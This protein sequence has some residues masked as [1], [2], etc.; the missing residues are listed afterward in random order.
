MCAWGTCVPDP[1]CAELSKILF[2]VHKIC[3]FATEHAQ[4]NAPFDGPTTIASSLRSAWSSSEHMPQIVYAV[5]SGAPRQF[6][7]VQCGTDLCM[8]KCIPGY[9]YIWNTFSYM[10]THFQRHSVIACGE[11]L[12]N[13]KLLKYLSYISNFPC[14]F[15]HYRPNIFKIKTWKKISINVLANQKKE[16]W[17]RLVAHLLQDFHLGGS[18]FI[19][20]ENS[21]CIIWVFLNFAIC[22]NWTVYKNL[23]EFI[24]VNS[25]VFCGTSGK[26]RKIV[27]KF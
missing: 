7:A 3:M 24:R 17:A 2:G 19:S 4:N 18:R 21:N 26:I 9:M 11:W 16:A 15:S 5:H 14:F 13:T 1:I 20:W 8:L 25:G 27:E 22:G 6:G 12:S 23:R 10:C